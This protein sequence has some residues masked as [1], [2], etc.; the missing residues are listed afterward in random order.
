MFPDGDKRKWVGAT[1]RP[2]TAGSSFKKSMASMIQEL[3]SKVIVDIC[4]ENCRILVA[5]IWCSIGTKLHTVCQ[6]K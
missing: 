3:N 2:E 5:N 4:S 6:T 1:K